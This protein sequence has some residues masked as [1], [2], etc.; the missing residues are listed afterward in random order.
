MRSSR[1]GFT[2]V[3]TL[4]AVIVLSV[5]ALALASSGGS[6]TRMLSNGQRKTRAATVAATILDSLRTKA[7]SAIPKCSGLA[8]GTG[9]GPVTAYGNQY[10]TAWDVSGAGTSRRIEV[11]VAYR[12]GPRVH[13]DTLVATIHPPC[14]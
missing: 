7:Y 13:G 14:P 1:A 4:V 12:V 5:G 8:S 11:R 3:E 2:I 10:T 6:I 9:S